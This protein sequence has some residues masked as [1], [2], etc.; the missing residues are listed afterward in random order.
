M[1]IRSIGLPSLG[2]SSVGVPSLVISV[3]DSSLFL[4]EST[5]IGTNLDI[6]IVLSLLVSILSD[7]D[8][9]SG[10]EIFSK[11]LSF[12]DSNFLRA[13]TLSSDTIGLIFT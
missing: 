13:D 12:I 10:F 6:S 9:G 11:L 7:V 5:F 1:G 4:S 2:V 8:V 3:L